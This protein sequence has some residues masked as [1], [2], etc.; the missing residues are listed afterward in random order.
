MDLVVS[1]LVFLTAVSFA[2]AALSLR[3]PRPV[4]NR[5]VRL[6]DGSEARLPESSRETSTLAT[7]DSGGGWI[8]R[9]LRTL[10]G[11]T[12]RAGSASVGPLR[13]RLIHAGYRRESAVSVYM[14]ARIALAIAGPA[15]LLLTP[16]AWSLP[17]WRLVPL[18]CAASGIGYLLPSWV[19]GRRVKS[20]QRKIEL[21]LPDALDL[22][23]VCVEAGL[24]INASLAR[25]AAEFAEGNP[26]LSAEFELVSLEI[27]AGKSTVAA[28]RSLAERSGVSEIRSLVALLVQTER[29]GTS[30]AAALR[31]HADAMRVRRMQRAEEQAGKAPLKM[32][33]PTVLIFAA[34]L[35]VL[36]TP[37][38]L[39]FDKMFEK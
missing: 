34:T 33:F 21:G 3:R 29:F 37:A 12:V 24:G 28:L 9:A 7:S 2:I 38:V 19:L 4:R 35:I 27:R 26:I 16:V 22:M 8:I 32:I 30:V 17:E 5:L 25:V 1:G 20:R 11:S 23:V 39:R 15:V 18:L 31:V 13:G 14:G 6:A 36:L 10:G